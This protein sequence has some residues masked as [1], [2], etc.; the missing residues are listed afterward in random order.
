M[1]KVRRESPFSQFVDFN[2]SIPE[3]FRGA[4]DVRLVILGQDPTVKN[5][6][7]RK[8]I[9]VVLNLDKP[10]AL[11]RF[12]DRICGSLGIGIENVY[13]TNGVKNFFV[14]PPTKIAPKFP[15]GVSPLVEFI[16]Y[17][18]PMLREELSE[19]ENV[20]TI[21]LGQPILRAVLCNN[22]KPNMRYYWGHVNNWKSGERKA[23]HFIERCDNTLD[24]KIFPFPHQP[25][26]SRNEY[27]QHRLEE[28][29]RFMKD[30]I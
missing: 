16:R 18:L 3:V 14:D 4:G 6:E 13:A 29:L 9:K 8:K 5:R 2:L 12:I 11:R 30:N 26:V 28:Y 7:S 22:T 10:Y 1:E 25:C 19:Y 20:P 15:K 27:Y 17:W 24:R 23:F 21:L